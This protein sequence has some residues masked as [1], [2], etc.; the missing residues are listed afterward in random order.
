MNYF[1]IQKGQGIRHVAFGFGQSHRTFD[2]IY[3]K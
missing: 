2:S 1:V 3:E